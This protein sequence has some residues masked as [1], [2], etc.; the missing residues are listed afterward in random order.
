MFS[1]SFIKQGRD[2]NVSF[3]VVDYVAIFAH[4][5]VK[6]YADTMNI[7]DVICERNFT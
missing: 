5:S 6:I 7:I 2:S 1:P 4:L 3:P